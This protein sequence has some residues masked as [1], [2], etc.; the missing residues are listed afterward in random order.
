MTQT[1]HDRILDEHG[2]IVKPGHPMY[3][4]LRASLDR[5]IEDLLVNLKVEAPNGR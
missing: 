4:F 1:E 3:D 2:H 5:A